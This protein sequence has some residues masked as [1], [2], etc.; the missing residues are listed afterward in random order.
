MGLWR[1]VGLIISNEIKEL[2]I[3]KSKKIIQFLEN[4]DVISLSNGK[5]DLGDDC[6]VVVNEYETKN[7]GEIIYEAHE[8]YIDVQ[9]LVY[10]EEAVWI[11][12]KENSICTRAYD[13]ENDYALYNSKNG[14]KQILTKGMFMALYPNDLHAPGYSSNM[15]PCRVK[16]LVFK[17]K[18]L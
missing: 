11:T 18:N 1:I 14:V 6:Y 15:M 7:D 13:L 12:D 17:I 3:F 8:K 10:G 2:K 4:N 9:F 5:Y 16:K